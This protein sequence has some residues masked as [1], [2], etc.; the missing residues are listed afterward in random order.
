MKVFSSVALYGCLHGSLVPR[1]AGWPVTCARFVCAGV[2]V[3]CASETPLGGG[4]VFTSRAV[5]VR[6]RVYC[7]GG[8]FWCKRASVRRA[9]KVRRRCFI[10]HICR[11][12]VRGAVRGVDRSIGRWAMPAGLLCCPN[13]YFAFP[14]LP[15]FGGGS[16]WVGVSVGMTTV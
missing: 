4:R 11:A 16:E 6:S 13:P 12:G 10:T 15:V 7:G 3:P 9:L 14:G 8:L 1:P 2:G 5:G